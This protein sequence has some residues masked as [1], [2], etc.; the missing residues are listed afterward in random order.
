MGFA[1][2]WH[3]VGFCDFDPCDA[4]LYTECLLEAQTWSWGFG[5]ATARRSDA[6]IALPTVSKVG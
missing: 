3:I 2:N 6:N 1:M 4:A 5:D